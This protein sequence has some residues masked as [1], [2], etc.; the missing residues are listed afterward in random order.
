[1]QFCGEVLTKGL[2]S[3]TA[4]HKGGGSAS[5]AAKPDDPDFSFRNPRGGMRTTHKLSSDFLTR[6]LA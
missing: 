2:L 6:A 5:K 4:K 3:S 1:M